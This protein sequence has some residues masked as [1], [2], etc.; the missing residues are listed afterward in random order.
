MTTPDRASQPV[1]PRPRLGTATARPFVAIGTIPGYHPHRRQNRLALCVQPRDRRIHVSRL[2][3]IQ[4]R[5]SECRV[6]RAGQP[7]P[8]SDRDP[9]LPSRRRL[10]RRRYQSLSDHRRKPKS[11]GRRLVA[12]NRRG[13][14]HT[15]QLLQDTQY[16]PTN[17]GVSLFGGTATA[18]ALALSTVAHESPGI[19]HLVRPTENAGAAVAARLAAGPPAGPTVYQQISQTCHGADRLGTEG[20]AP[21]L[22]YPTRPIQRTTS[23]PVHHTSTRRQFTRSSGQG[24]GTDVRVPWLT[25]GYLTSMTS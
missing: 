20:G 21:P 13:H 10:Y 18:R 22:I 7:R 15:D 19:L 1:G 11:T 23:S 9:H 12:A 4:F 2:K 16:V 6:K 8:L 5:R 14:L 3:N 24:E 25:R 17:D